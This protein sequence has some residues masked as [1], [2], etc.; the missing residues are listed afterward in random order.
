MAQDGTRATKKLVKTSQV[1]VRGF[2]EFIR[3]QGVMGL[4]VGLVLGTAV[5]ALVTSMINNLIMPPIG[6]LLGSANGLRG[7]SLVIGYT[8]DGAPVVMAYGSFLNDAIN[9][10]V[11][12]LVIY[13][14]VKLF[15]IEISK[16]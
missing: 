5:T 10:L 16:K 2:M 1:Q 3:S 11:I 9:F 15:D 14:F 13:I 12:A 4:A 8:P 6:L 7:L